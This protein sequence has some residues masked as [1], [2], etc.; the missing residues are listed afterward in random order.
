MSKL[1]PML[2]LLHMVV[3]NGDF[4]SGQRLEPFEGRQMHAELDGAGSTN[5]RALPLAVSKR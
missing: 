2:L 4:R 1:N 3:A 5:P